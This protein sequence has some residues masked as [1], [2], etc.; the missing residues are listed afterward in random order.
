VLDLQL[1]PDG[2]AG[3]GAAGRGGSPPVLAPNEAQEVHGPRQVRARRRAGPFWRGACS[4]PRRAASRA[5]PTSGSTPAPMERRPHGL[6]PEV[7]L[8]RRR[9]AR[10]RAACPD[11]SGRRLEA[12][13]PDALP[14]LR[15]RRAH[16]SCPS[17][18]RRAV[19]TRRR[20]RS[21]PARSGRGPAPGAA[22]R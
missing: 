10:C 14:P 15:T 3:G 22:A 6:H 1:D 16:W 5:T 18:A 12:L 13:A 20:S 21:S 9:G 2:E 4:A 19:P 17:P 7:D 11:R 8:H